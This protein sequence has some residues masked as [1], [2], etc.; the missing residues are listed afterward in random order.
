MLRV[1]F[2]ALAVM[3]GPVSNAAIIDAAWSLNGSGNW[4]TAANWD[5]GVVPH[6]NAA[7]QFNVRIDNDDGVDVIVSLNTSRTIN[8]LTVDDGD[9]LS[10]LNNIDL[11]IAGSSV[12]NDGMISLNSAG[13]LTDLIFQAPVATLSGTGTLT[14]GGNANNRVFGSAATNELINSASHTIAGAGQLGVSFNKLTN[15]GLVNANDAAG[16]LT[17]DPGSLGVINSGTLQASNGGRLRLQGGT[18][19]GTSGGTIHAAD[20]SFVELGQDGRIEGGTLTTAGSGRIRV[21]NNL[22]PIIAGT[23]ANNGQWEMISTGSLTDMRVDGATTLTGAGTLTLIG[24]Q[25]NRIFGVSANAVL[26]NG[27]GHTIAGQG[28]LGANFLGLVN[29]GLINADDA[30][31]ALLTIDP[32]GSGATNTGEL[33]SSGGGR[34]RLQG[35]TFDSTGGGTL[36]AADGS[37]VELGDDGRIEGG[38]FTTAGSGRIQVPNNL[39]P[40]IAGTITNNGQW[41]VIS[42]GS[43]TDVRVD[44]NVTLTGN[45]T[46]TLVGGQNNRIFGLVDG[47]V[48]TNDAEHTIAGQGQ[49]GL[50]FNLDLVNKGLIDA[51]DAAALTI[52]PSTQATNGISG[53]WRGSGTAGLTLTGGTFDNQGAVEALNGSNVTYS[54]SAV[55]AN[56]LSGVLTRGK[57]RAISTGGAA[58]ITLRGANITQIAADAEVEL[59]G[60]GAELKVSATPLESSLMSNAGTLR[61]SD[62][63]TFNTS[64]AFTNTG[65]VELSDATLSSNISITNSVGGA[66]VG[67]GRIDGTLVSEGSLE[68]NSAAEFLEINGTVSGDG[69]MK[70]VRIDGTHIVGSAGGA[71]IVPLEGSYRLNGNTVHLKIDIDGLTPGTEHDQLS[72]NGTVQ[73]GGIL[74][75]S[76]IQLANDYRAS[77]GDRFTI[78]TSTTPITGAFDVANLPSLGGR[79]AL[80]WLPV[81]Y[82]SPNEVVLEIATANPFSA[83]YDHDGDVDGNDFLIWQRGGSPNTLSASDLAAWREEYGNAGGPVGTF[84]AAPEPASAILLAATAV[85]LVGLTRV[86]RICLS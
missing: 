6:N 47:S 70:D 7:D 34:L 8:E 78:V 1:I 31:G 61:I 12:G 71:A 20:G 48:L 73:I 51:T 83:D 40:I 84:V 76:P 42:A 13:S 74:D 41:D 85:W 18:F 50:N 52:D 32:S 67:Q 56:N 25:N 4:S 21:P 11:S 72:S 39:D 35:G 55:T 14:L 45:G 9:E 30:S 43:L 3:L 63:R 69:G 54:S 26:T 23:I 64:N 33:R 65:T 86:T 60:A 82:S 24:N 46:L 59:S 49:I 37:F 57:W 19:S 16:T 44:G 5:I 80:T 62:L 81:D 53:T 27:A 29:A 58:T 22:D 68:G 28:Q 77:A 66:I 10:V 36:H 75:V 2:G 17:V 79:A 38:T 15:E